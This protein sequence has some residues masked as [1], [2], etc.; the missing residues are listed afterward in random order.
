MGD[1]FVHAARNRTSCV[2]VI[3]QRKVK[4]G[5]YTAQVLSITG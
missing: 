3:A 4:G 5:R 2:K 1:D